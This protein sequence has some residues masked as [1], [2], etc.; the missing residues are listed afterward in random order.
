[1]GLK[2]S[3][4]QLAR[5]HSRQ[6]RDFNGF[7]WKSW[8]QTD[9]GSAVS[10]T[11]QRHSG[12]FC[13]AREGVSSTASLAYIICRAGTKAVAKQHLRTAK[14]RRL[15]SDEDVNGLQP[16]RLKLSGK[17]MEQSEAVSAVYRSASFKAPPPDSLA[18]ALWVP[19][20]SGGRP[21]P[22]GLP[23]EI[24]SDAGKEISLLSTKGRSSRF[25]QPDCSYLSHRPG[26]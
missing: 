20:S 14:T 12:Y 17:A 15:V 3:H 19:T 9:L 1:M 13:P 16:N 4:F 18:A 11:L 24:L 8:K 7:M 6:N 5:G 25:L 23:P 21:S 2:S 10:R 22:V 26:S